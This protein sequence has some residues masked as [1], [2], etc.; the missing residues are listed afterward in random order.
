MGQILS[1][2]NSTILDK[3]SIDW[4]LLS[5]DL[6]P[7]FPVGLLTGED[8]PFLLELVDYEE[9][10]DFFVGD[11]PPAA[12]YWNEPPLPI[13]FL[14]SYTKSTAYWLVRQSQIPSHAIIIKSWAGFRVSTITSGKAETILSSGFNYAF[15]YSQSPIAL[16]IAI[17]PFTLPSSTNPPA[18]CTLLFS[19][20][21]SGLWS[22]DKSLAV[23]FEAITHL[24]SP[25]FAQYIS[26]LVMR[27]TQAVQPA[28]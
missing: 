24:V 11:D 1:I 19:A 25:A 16:E 23:P 9:V 21:K 5:G 15:L 27:A 22:I 13:F 3:L 2:I 14:Y 18:L 12:A 17:I 4:P 10:V 6:E 20:G 26:V 7:I 8:D 28:W